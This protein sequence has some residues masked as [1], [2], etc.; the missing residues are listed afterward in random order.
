MKGTI[1]KN[2]GALLVAQFATAAISIVVLILA[3][4]RL[5]D[6][7]FGELTVAT[8]YLT[9][10]T[11]L[12]LA[13]SN[14]FLVKSIARDPST[15]GS[16]V[17]NTFAMKV[18]LGAVLTVVAV[19]L[20]QLLGY[21]DRLCV[22]ITIGCVG[23][24]TVA[25]NDAITAG[26]QGL[27]RMARPAMWSIA[28]QYV[29]SG[30]GILVLLTNRG[31]ILYAIT[32]SCFGLVSL[33]PNMMY[34]WPELRGNLSIRFPVWKTV[35]VGG[36]PF[37]TW[38]AVSLIYG[39]IDILMLEK[40]TNDATVGWYG[41]AW[42]WVG[43]P[44]F[45][46]AHVVTV[47]LPSLSSR[48]TG[49]SPDFA[50]L[51][52]RAL[53]LVIFVGAPAAAGIALVAQPMLAFLYPPAFQNAVAP[54]R[55]LAL[56]IPFVAMDMILGIALVA[57]DRHKQWLAVGCIAA[58][59]NPLINLGLIP[60]TVSHFSNGAIGAA[61]AT[62]ATEALM[63]AG[64]IRLRPRGVLD[65]PTA[66]FLGRCLVAAVCIVPAGAIFHDKGLPI[67]VVIGVLTYG[68][69]SLLLKTT[70]VG[71]VASVIDKGRQIVMTRRLPEPAT[72]TSL[73][74]DKVT[75]T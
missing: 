62:V 35:F 63:M 15:V 49:D 67:Q 65:R 32:L 14:I 48:G 46:S 27:E 60:L 42:A 37:A 40:M 41:V 66:G 70:S 21:S 39:S 75:V 9:F 64:A 57:R 61:I 56:H 34:L 29:T 5:G 33:I 52:N 4:R 59:F 50:S 12:A 20:A 3:P 1:G 36:L 17:V 26:L 51:A 73:D 11:L 71:Q 13:G 69:A 45:F 22:L 72:E 38:A 58:L 19:G 8:T 7:Q 54:L 43:F 2:L 23:M 24:V 44:A 31:L 10:F 18:C 55:I 47:F 16:Y 25:L 53:R 68:V 30:L 74:S 6:E 28:Q